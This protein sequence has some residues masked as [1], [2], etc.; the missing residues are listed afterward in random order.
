M[1]TRNAAAGLPEAFPNFVFRH[2]L[3]VGMHDVVEVR[4][5]GM[6]GVEGDLNHVGQR[7]H[8]EKRGARLR[9][10]DP[11]DP[12]PSSDRLVHL[13]QGIGLVQMMLAHQGLDVCLLVFGLRAR[14]A[15]PF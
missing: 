7:L 4:M 3:D 12:V 10:L 6:A 13:L 15:G 11:A 5:D 14:L 9:G 8:V 2:F 1:S